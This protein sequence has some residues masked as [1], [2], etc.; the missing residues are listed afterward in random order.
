MTRKEETSRD[1]KKTAPDQ[2][3]PCPDC[4]GTGVI[5]TSDVHRTRPICCDRCETGR[6]IWSRILE[7]LTDMDRPS[8]LRTRPEPSDSIARGQ[9]PRLYTLAAPDRSKSGEGR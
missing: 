4:K 7:L 1:D 9:T 2:N 3:T 5:L 6:A 8:P